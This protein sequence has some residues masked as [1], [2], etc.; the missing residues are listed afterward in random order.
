MRKKL[1]PVLGYVD[2]RFQLVCVLCILSAHPSYASKLKE[3]LKA[4]F[5]LDV[6]YSRVYHWLWALERDGYAQS[7]LALKSGHLIREYKMTHEGRVY[8]VEVIKFLEG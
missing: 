7:A 6:K 8:L 3:Q 1:S 4:K 5:N 2:R